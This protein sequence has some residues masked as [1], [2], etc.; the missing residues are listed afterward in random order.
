[1]T[2]SPTP[3]VPSAAAGSRIKTTVVGSYPV[4]DWLVATPSDQG[5]ID[6]TR[7]VIATQEAA[8][9]D[10]VCDGELYRFDIDHPETN[11]MIEYFVRPMQGVRYELTFDEVMAYRALPG[12]RFRTRPPG[13][14]DGPISSGTL[15]LPLA[16]H[17]AQALANRDFKFTVT[18]PHMLAKTLLDRHYGDTAALAHA[19]AEVLAEQVRH[20]DADVVQIDEANLPGHPE[21]WEW[22]AAAI[23]RVLDAVKTT[24][25]VHLCFGNYGGQSVQSG[26]WDRLMQYL[27]ALHADHVVL[28]CA[29]RPAEELEVFKELR[30]EIGLGLGV[31][32]IKATEIESAEAVARAIERAEKTLGAGRVKYIHPDCGFWMLKRPIADAKIRALAQ[33]RDLYEGRRA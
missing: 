4:P 2:A 8:G 23:N 26:T 32:D 22:A 17:R 16:C 6:A 27:N 3:E 20:L 10:V 21:E 25:A 19:I 29:H 7:V 33:G 18:G 15:D 31:V 5:L 24:P 14:V 1:V 12:M 30:P 13:V 9:V 28:E 11:G